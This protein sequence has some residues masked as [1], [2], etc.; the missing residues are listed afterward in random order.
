MLARGYNGSLPPQ[1][2][3]AMTMRD[4]ALLWLGIGFLVL[5][6]LLGLWSLG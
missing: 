5:I 4:L 6:W 2:E 1:K 3:Q